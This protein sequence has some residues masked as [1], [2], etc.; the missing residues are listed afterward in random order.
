[1]LGVDT[2]TLGKG[3]TNMNDQ[4]V[5]MSLSPDEE[6]RFFVPR[7]F[8]SRFKGLLGSHVPKALTNV[9][10]DAH[11]FANAGIELGGPWADTVVLDFL[12]D[13]DTRENRHSL[14]QCAKDYFGIPMKE[15]NELFGKVKIMDIKPGHEL[16]EKFIDYASL[17]AWASRKLA[18]FLLE[19]LDKIYMDADEGFTLKQHYWD[20]EALQMKTLYNMER[21]GFRINA[22]FLIDFG[23]DLQAR[24]DEVAKKLSN[25]LQWPINPNSTKQVIKMLFEDMGFKP[26]S[27]TKG[28]APQVDEKSLKHFANEKDVEEC[29]LILEYRGYGKLKGTYCDGI[30]SRLHTDGRVHTTFNATMTTGRLSSSNPNLQNIPIRS[31]DGARIRSAFVAREGFKLIVADYGQLEMRILAF[32]ANELSMI[33]AINDGLDMHSG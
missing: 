26:I 27:L 14:K 10:F 12:L 7:K 28:G 1:M 31:K 17:D 4:I 5:C 25:M 16:W 8:V 20:T 6:S 32:M 15:Y 3:H 22:Q 24:M 13:E 9:K 11:R 30:V 21:R 33:Q 23:N 19:E 2:E 18:L 29:K